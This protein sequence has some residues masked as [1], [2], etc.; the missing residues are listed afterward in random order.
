MVANPPD[1]IYAFITAVLPP[2]HRKEKQ[3]ILGTALHVRTGAYLETVILPTRQRVM[4]AL[5]VGDENAHAHH[6][7]RQATRNNYVLLWTDNP[8]EEPDIQAYLQKK[9]AVATETKSKG[10]F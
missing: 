9:H 1:K 2:R 6:K 4:L 3:A 5:G 7:Y 10:F 8:Q